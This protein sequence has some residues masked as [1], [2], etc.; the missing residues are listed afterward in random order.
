MRT[1][2]L[3]SALVAA[4]ALAAG[5]LPG[6]AAA[7]ARPWPLF[8]AGCR[9]ADFASPAGPVR[10]EACEPLEAQAVHPAVVV[11][12]GCGGFGGLDRRLAEQLPRIGVAT[13]YVDY[14]WPTPPPSR[15]GWCGGGARSVFDTWQ[16]EVVAAAS[17][18]G[19]LPGVAPGRIGV[20]GWSLGA[21]LALVTAEDGDAP[22]GAPTR[23]R[24][25]FAPSSRTRGAPSGPCWTARAACLP[26]WCS[27]PAP[28][29]PCRSPT[30]SRCTAR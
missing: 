20:V 7:A 6:P 8:D 4:A 10:A 22:L 30:P 23:P 24:D 28:P 13:L 1:R 26:P 9:R 2:T 16:K 21:G 18:A 12:Y 19:R 29:T 15:R 17:A 3:V 11:L 25:C 5:A 14:F 27:R